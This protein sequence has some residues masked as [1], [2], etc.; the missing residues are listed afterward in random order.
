MIMKNF[1]YKYRVSLRIMAFFVCALLAVGKWM[2]FS[3]TG[4]GMDMV[5]G[6]IWSAWALIAVWNL[7]G[8]FKKREDR[9]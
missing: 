6:I 3:R 9:I 7:I 5:G 8:T 2:D 1:L 4:K